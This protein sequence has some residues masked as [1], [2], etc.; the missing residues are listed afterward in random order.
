MVIP[1]LVNFG[2]SPEPYWESGKNENCADVAV[3]TTPGL[4]ANE[5]EPDQVERGA[6]AKQEANEGDEMGV[7]PAI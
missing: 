2:K 5:P 1:R 3:V 6:C 7:K 4:T